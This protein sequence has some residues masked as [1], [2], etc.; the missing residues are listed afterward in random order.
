VIQF[1]LCGITNIDDARAA[2][3]NGASAIGFIFYKR[4][5]RYI[6]PEAARLIATQLNGAVKTVG[7]FVNEPIDQVNDIAQ[8]VNLDFVQLH[9]GE[10]PEY[11]EKIDRAVIKSFRIGDGYDL[12]QINDYPVDAVLLDTFVKGSAGG[13]GET[14]QWNDFDYDAINK[15]LILAGGLTPD[16]VSQG[17]LSVHPD[18]I[19][20][21]SGVEVAP[22]K[23]DA[24][25]IEQ[26]G[27]VLKT[28]DL[29]SERLIF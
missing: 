29:N 24:A 8:R 3:K 19:D 6:E 27:Q 10:S 22:G 2:A 18:A 23:K 5:P 1:K 17:I 13:T 26:L 11:C 4:S 16:N 7:V 12:F 25:K 20:I 9:G 14:F 21:S 15:P 28:I